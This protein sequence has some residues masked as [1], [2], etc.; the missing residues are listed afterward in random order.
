M[1]LPTA[2]PLYTDHQVASIQDAEFDSLRDTPYQTSINILL[3]VGVFEVRF[4]FR[5]EERIDT[6]VQVRVL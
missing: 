1:T 4:R 3:P 6:A 2:P 5:I